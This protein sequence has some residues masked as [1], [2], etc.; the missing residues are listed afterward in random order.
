MINIEFKLFIKDRYNSWNLKRILGKLNLIISL[1]ILFL[2]RKD[3]NLSM[4]KQIN[5]TRNLVNI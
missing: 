5:I 4:I 1:K 2:K 3:I